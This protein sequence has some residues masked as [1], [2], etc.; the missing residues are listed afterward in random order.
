MQFLALRGDGSDASS[1]LIQLL[2]L[3]AEDKLE[4]WLDRSARKH[5][6]PENP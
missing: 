2:R 4:E 6:V 3:R 1:N 5:T